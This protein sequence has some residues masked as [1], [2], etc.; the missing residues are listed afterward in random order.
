VIVGKGG[1]YK[2]KVKQYILNN[3]LEDHFVWL[4]NLENNTHLQALYQKAELFVYPSIYEGFGIPVVEAL[5]S[6]TAV[7]TSNVSSLPE[8][9][10]PNSICIDPENHVIMMESIQNI[11]TQPFLK[12]EMEEK[13]YNYAMANFDGIE[14]SQKLLD[15]YKKM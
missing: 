13:G 4:D 10:G 2:N 3:Q 8:A 14:C 12:K 6:K 11:L 15:I 7:I 1:A 9:A 5:L